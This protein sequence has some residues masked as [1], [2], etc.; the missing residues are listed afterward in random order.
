[1]GCILNFL[2]LG[3]NLSCSSWPTPHPGQHQIQAASATSASACGNAGAFNPLSEA[4]DGTR[5]LTETM[6]DP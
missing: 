5:I 4:R 2:G 6:S 1:M 3:V